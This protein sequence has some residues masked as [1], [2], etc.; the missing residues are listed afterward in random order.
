MTEQE[1]AKKLKELE[2]VRVRKSLA[3]ARKRKLEAQAES[4]E[5]IS[6]LESFGRGAA[7][8]ATLGMAPHIAE[9]AG[10]EEDSVEKFRAAHE[11]NPGAY[12]TGD[13]G[14]A[15]VPALMSGGASVPAQIAAKT[16]AKVGAKGLARAAAPKTI[17]GMAKVG[18]VEGAIEGAA[19]SDSEN[20]AG[21]VKDAAFGGTVGLVAPKA[22]D[23]GGEA[24]RGGARMTGDVAKKTGR[25]VAHVVGKATPAGTGRYRKSMRDFVSKG[26]MKGGVSPEAAGTYKQLLGDRKRLKKALT[27][28]RTYRAD[29]AG[30]QESVKKFREQAK[31]AVSRHYEKL[32]NVADQ[33]MGETYEDIL[34]RGKNVIAESF[35]DTKTLKGQYSGNTRAILKQAHDII[36][37][38]SRKVLRGQSSKTESLIEARR[39]LDLNINHAKKE[40]LSLDAELL[41]DTRDSLDQ[42]FKESPAL[43]KADKFWKTYKDEARPMLDSFTGRGKNAERIN[44][45]SVD[46]WIRDAGGAGAIERDSLRRSFQ[47]FVDANPGM[48]YKRKG[49]KKG[50]SLTSNSLQT[51]E[52]KFLKYRDAQDIRTLV[53][54]SGGRT[55]KSLGSS[56]VAGS[57]MGGPIGFAVT[58][59]MQPT[60][61]PAQYLKNIQTV[62][63]WL[64][65][66]DPATVKK[67]LGPA[68]QSVIQAVRAGA[69]RGAIKE[70]LYQSFDFGEGSTVTPRGQ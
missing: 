6:G 19:R 56:L 55:G 52:D 59:I 16:L 32:K 65:K 38:K 44:T 60:N 21:T 54:E 25:G 20:L 50:G 49:T 8:G 23:L 3:V 27:A 64:A 4:E 51:F 40:G 70:D 29:S 22:F 63:D 53:S 11:A 39:H 24:I 57:L 47:K 66:T 36:G 14:A 46:S 30:L 12:N 7:E 45:H 9:W 10:L 67:A 33:E 28:E 13:Y 43:S 62:R 5:E 68:Y 48:S 35:Q 41:R 26:A 34:A 15:I 42:I 58:A 2:L 31:N 61:N 17:G 1:R 18:L 37:G 69:Q